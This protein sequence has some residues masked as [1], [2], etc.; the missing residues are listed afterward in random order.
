MLMLFRRQT[1]QRPS[2]DPQASDINLHRFESQT[3]LLLV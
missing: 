1:G 3:V 2:V